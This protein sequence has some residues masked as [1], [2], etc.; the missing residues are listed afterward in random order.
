MC[1]EGV[2][3]SRGLRSGRHIG[4]IDITENRSQDSAAFPAAVC[5]SA[6]IPCWRFHR[7]NL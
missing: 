1:A 7:R 2:L 5:I 6:Y 4:A 3:A